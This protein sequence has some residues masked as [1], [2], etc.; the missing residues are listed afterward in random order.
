MG[1]L[2]K[3]ALVEKLVGE[4]G[5]WWNHGYE[6]PKMTSSLYPYKMMFSPITIN[7]LTI[8]NRLVM[9]P[10]GNIDMCEET[11]RPNNRMLRY[12]EERAKGGVGLI[13]SGL[14]P[15][16]YGIDKSLIE[17]GDLTY[18][19]R[20]D[21]SRTVFEAW[22]DLSKICHAHGADFFIQITAGLG[23]V[24]NPQ[25]LIT[26]H[27][28]P[29][30]ASFLPNWYM[31]DV[32]CLRL[33]DHSLKK[34][35]KNIG[36]AA[37]DA[38]SANIDGIYLH[39]HEGYLLEQLTNPAFNHRKI[40]RY[41]NYEHFGIDTIK[42]IRKRVGPN[43]PIMYRIDLTLALNEVYGE[44][45]STISPLKKFSK[46]RTIEMTLAYMDKLVKAG[47]DLFDVD[48]GCY[49]DWWLPHPPMS[50]PSACYLDLSELAKKHFADKGIKTNAGRDVPVVGVGK[51]GYP[52]LA[53]KALRDNKCDM[54]MLGRPLLAD[55]EWPN[56]AF[57]GKV[58]EIRP[59][60]GCQEGC[61]NEFVEGGHPQCA[62]NPRTAFEEELSLEIP[63]APIKKNVAVIGGGPAGIIAAKTLLDRGHNVTLYEK[64][65]E[66]GGELIPGSAPKI[67]YEIA[68]YLDF[69]RRTVKKLESSPDFKVLVG[70]EATIDLLRAGHYDVII[71]AT[72]ARQKKPPVTGFDKANVFFATDVLANPSLLASATD[73]V[74]VGAGSVGCEVAYFLAYEY[75]KTVKVIE[76]D[77]YVMNHVCTANRGH[78]IHYLEAKGVEILVMTQALSYDGTSLSV[79]QCVDPRVPNPFNTWSP[80]LPENISNPLDSTAKIDPKNQV[81]KSLKADAV[82]VATGGG[83]DNALYFQLVANNAA[84]EIYNLGDSFRT[85]RVFE[86]VHAAYRK[87]RLI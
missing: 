31:K 65:K 83:S 2:Q 52:D 18:F 36:Q 12:F 38:K 32:P 27:A 84:K 28:F 7:R 55:A 41:A 68:N 34:I 17:L 73:V 60:I 22:R 64:N 4:Y 80:I 1:K 70:T 66:L 53:E 85:G 33:S 69:L 57:A 21:R 76:M 8:K 16:S 5:D 35:I 19:P 86:A 81:I 75:G 87:A 43:Y 63:K 40:G 15:V 62:I 50:M 46:G 26:Q 10:M 47:V 56:K 6:T 61:L 44:R 39:G 51:L 49:D 11:G 48:M 42:E 71:T 37:A 74:V 20:I 25:C 9:A 79:S 82:V 3:D 30:S 45:M 72:G 13:T 23:R 59:C 24:G 29:R 54:V 77:K 78:V 58:D 14:I 67:K